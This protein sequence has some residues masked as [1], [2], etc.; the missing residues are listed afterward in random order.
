MGEISKNLRVMTN[1]GTVKLK[2]LIDSGAEDNFIRLNIIEKMIIKGKMTKQ[3]YEKYGGRKRFIGPEGDFDFPDGTKKIGYLTGL[4]VYWRNRFIET[5]AVATE[6]I[7]EQLVLGQPFLQDNHV[8]INF[9]N[10][11]FT[12][13]KY[14]PKYHKIPRL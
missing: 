5:R 11:S 7:Q 9:K 2:V 8:I 4:R 14:A 12:L 1:W 13:G 10:D 6:D 3:A